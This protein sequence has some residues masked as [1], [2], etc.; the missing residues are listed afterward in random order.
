MVP[1]KSDNI[2]LKVIAMGTRESDNI[3]QSSTDST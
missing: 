2:N 3:N 1:K